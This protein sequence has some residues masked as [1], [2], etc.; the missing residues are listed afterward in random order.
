M[1][2]KGVVGV[3]GSSVTEWPPPGCED[4]RD[5][6]FNGPVVAKSTDNSQGVEN[7]PSPE[8]P[9]FFGRIKS[10]IPWT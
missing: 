7:S 6:A 2:G 5:H 1:A 9:T 3:V 8:A 10:I 4:Y